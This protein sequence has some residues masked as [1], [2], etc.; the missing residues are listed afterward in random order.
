MELFIPSFAVLLVCFLLFMFVM[1]RMSPYIL[2]VLCIIMFGVGVWQH[3][4]M[5][6]YE[7]RASMV[8]DMLREYSGF[9]MLIAIIFSILTVIYM[10]NGTSGSASNVTLIPEVKSSNVFGNNSSKNSSKSIFNSA[11]NGVSGAINNVSKTMTNLMKPLNQTK[12]NN[13]VSPSFKVS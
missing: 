5:F 8:T 2:G 6:P 9:I 10:F 4:S 1:P 11:S 13:L 7:Y 12:S 3:Y